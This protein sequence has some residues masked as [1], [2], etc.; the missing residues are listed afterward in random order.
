[1]KRIRE[2]GATHLVLRSVRF[3]LDYGGGVFLWNFY[4]PF[5][6]FTLLHP[7]FTLSLIGLRIMETKRHL[8][9]EP[10]YNQT[11]HID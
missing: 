6:G 7:L 8:C 5:S 2:Q 4:S 1:M 3:C 10:W 11:G 9:T